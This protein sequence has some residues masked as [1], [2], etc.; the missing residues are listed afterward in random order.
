MCRS[1]TVPHMDE[2][3][4]SEARSTHLI[5][6]M[7]DSPLFPFTRELTLKPL[8]A[9]MA[10]ELPRDGDGDR[11]CHACGKPDRVLWSNGRWQVAS[12]RPS[13][14][15][16]VLFLET[17]EHVDF[18]QLNGEMAQE[19]GLLS[20]HLEAA[21]RVVP[22]V[23]RVHIHRWSDGSSHL[24]VWFQARPARQL[25]FYGWGNVLRPQV[26]E[27]LSAETVAANNAAVIAALDDRLR[28]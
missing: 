2:P 24:H 17:V 10:A 26:D 8:S 7:V 22:D 13:S 11:P 23:G 16:V 28:N 19:F 1:G 9:P 18:D 5:A 25:E 14:N 20:W 21:I 15:P 4:K 12:V 27:P 3:M 6:Q